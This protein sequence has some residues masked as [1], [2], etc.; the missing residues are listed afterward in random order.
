[1]LMA[2]CIEVG[3]LALIL[4]AFGCAL[5][6]AQAKD[7]DKYVKFC[8]KRIELL[9]SNGVIPYVV[10]DGDNLPMKKNTEQERKM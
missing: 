6:L 5:E 9:K 1:M 2:G 10:F 4:G 8:M 3:N 7:T